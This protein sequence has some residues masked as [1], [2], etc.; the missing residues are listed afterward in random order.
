MSLPPLAVF[1]FISDHDLILIG[2]GLVVFLAFVA[3]ARFVSGRVVIALRRRNVHADVVQIGAR[4]ATVVLIGTFVAI[5]MIPRFIRMPTSMPAEPST[6]IVPPVMPP[7]L[8]R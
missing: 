8:P 4:V 7:M 1:F 3:G 5:A 6:R 2:V